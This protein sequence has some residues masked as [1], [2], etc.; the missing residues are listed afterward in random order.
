M[1]IIKKI[2]GRLITIIQILLNKLSES[3]KKIFGHGLVNAKE[4]LLELNDMTPKT[5]RDHVSSV[6]PW[7]I[8][9]ATEYEE[10]NAVEE[11][12]FADCILW[13]NYYKGDENARKIVD[14]EGYDRDYQ[15]WVEKSLGYNPF[16]LN[17][18]DLVPTV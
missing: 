8:E 2:K 3:Y 11:Y 9:K 16:E 12:A 14:I 4:Q 10:R 13:E 5:I 7:L 17:E 6:D 15:I 1:A 18:W